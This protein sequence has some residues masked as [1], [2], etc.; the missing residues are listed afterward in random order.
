MEIIHVRTC[1]VYGPGLPRLRVP[2]TLI[3]AAVA[4]HK[5]HLP[6]GGDFRADHVY[7][8]DCVDGIVKALDKPSHHSDVYH[9]STGEAPSLAEIVAM[10][11]ELVPGADLA[12]GPGPYKFV[13]GTEA[14]RKGA[15]DITRARNELGLRAAFP[16]KE[17][18]RRLYRG[19]ARW[20]RLSAGNRTIVMAERFIRNIAQVPGGN[21]RTISVARSFV[22]LSRPPIAHRRKLVPA[23]AFGCPFPRPAR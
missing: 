19:D 6:S 17:R 4:G 8:D 16:D 14:V 23:L 15:L 21:S 9:I 3:D 2:K 22:R 13:D 1:W 10:I 12:I 5:L 11:K 18:P 20:P 7:I